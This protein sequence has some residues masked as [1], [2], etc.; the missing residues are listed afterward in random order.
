MAVFLTRME[1]DSNTQSNAQL[2][3]PL[4]A[5][6]SKCVHQIGKKRKEL[7]LFGMKA[8]ASLRY[9][10]AFQQ[11]LSQA[12]SVSL[13]RACRY[14]CCLLQVIVFVISLYSYY[15]LLFLVLITFCLFLLLC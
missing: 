13:S 2:P 3:V 6:A 1:A 7:F 5:G 11:T 14:F 12:Q 15:L 4:P 9:Q 8:A 10:F